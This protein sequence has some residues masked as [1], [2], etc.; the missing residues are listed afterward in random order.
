M[1]NTFATWRQFSAVILLG[2][3][4]PLMRVL[5]R[6]AVATAGAAA[7]LSVLFAVPVL[8]AI[9][10]FVSVLKKDLLPG[11]GLAALFPR[12][13]GFYGG[14]LLLLLFA[15][16]TLFYAGFILHSSAERLV[17]TVYPKTPLILFEVCML[18][19]CLLMSLGTFRAIARTSVILLAVLLVGLGVVLSFGLAEVSP[20]NLQF[21]L[22]G[23]LSDLLFG[24]LSSIS[25]GG[26]GILFFF[27]SGSVEPI[28]FKP[29]Q[30]FSF[31]LLFLLPSVFL[32][33]EV[34][35]VFG[36]TLTLRLSYPFF[37]MVRDISL[38]HVAQR[39]EAVVIV[40]WLFSDILLCLCMIRCSHE[41]FRTI[42]LLPATDDYPIFCLKHG[43]WLFFPESVLVLLTALFLPSSAYTMTAWSDKIIPLIS[44][45]FSLVI[46]PIVWGIGKLRKRA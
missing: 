9:I 29:R 24:S 6:T 28:S 32:C 37:V 14:R 12:N 19:L 46:V 42:F 2:L 10:L 36:P 45:G 8:I 16:W 4:S 33:L 21:S 7:W 41:I 40:M 31:L 22:S 25:V 43:R 27:L 1:K 11:E 3:L 13:L 34:I 5:P 35:G 20:E 30:G 23:K 15:G 39:V 44:D 18:L 38:F 26:V 17:A